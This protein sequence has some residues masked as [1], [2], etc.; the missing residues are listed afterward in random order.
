M[1]GVIHIEHPDPIA[2]VKDAI[3]N[4]CLGKPHFFD[5]SHCEMGI[6][7]LCSLFL[8]VDISMEKEIESVLDLPLPN[9]HPH[10]ISM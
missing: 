1:D 10:G 8:S 5:Q 6:P 3:I 4:C 2:L 7:N 9:L